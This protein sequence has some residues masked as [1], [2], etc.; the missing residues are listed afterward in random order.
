M[1]DIF[2]WSMVN[3]SQRTQ[4]WT[5]AVYKIFQIVL[6]FK[7]PPPPNLKDM[8]SVL[9][10]KCSLNHLYL[11]LKHTYRRET[12]KLTHILRRFFSPE[13]GI[14]FE[15]VTLSPTNCS[16]ILEVM[17]L[18]SWR[19]F[20]HRELGK[21]EPT[22]ST[23]RSKNWSLPIPWTSSAKQCFS[24]YASSLGSYLLSQNKLHLC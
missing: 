2:M 21:A 23:V 6:K 3:Q 20:S 19:H 4:N 13:S 14:T 9:R 10:Q 5:T 24:E 1:S 12:L 17:I 22:Y 15:I 11:N 8:P 16:A 18:L 7:S